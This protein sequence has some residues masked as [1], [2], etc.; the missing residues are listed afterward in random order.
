MLRAPAGAVIELI[1]VKLM[2]PSL[3]Q[4]S[5]RKNSGENLSPTGNRASDGHDRPANKLW[6]R[7]ALRENLGFGRPIES[8]VQTRMSGSFGTN[9]ET[10]RV[11]TDSS[12]ARMAESQDARAFTIGN[13]IVFGAGEYRPGV[14][15]GDMLLAHEIAHSL[16]QRGGGAA[17]S[18]SLAEDGANLAA[19]RALTRMEGGQGAPAVAMLRETGGLRLQRCQR[20]PSDVQRALDGQISWTPTLAEQAL[21]QYRGLSDTDRRT[22]FDR[23]YP[24]GTFHQLLQALPPGAAE[25]AYADVVRDV[26]QR[27]Q[28][29]GVMESARASGLPSEANMAQTQ[30]TFMQARNLAAAQ[31]A[32]PVMAPPPTQAQVAAQ[33]QTQVAQTSIPPSTNALSPA[34]IALWTT[35]TN[36]AI[37]TFITYTTANHPQLRLTAADLHTDVPGVEGRGQNVIAYGEVVGGRNVA[38]VGR[39]FVQYVQSNPAYALGTVMHELRG[40]P[41][42]GTYG[43]PGT[44]YGLT[45]YDMASARMP[46]YTQPTG[47]GRTSE[48]DA[49]AYQETEIYSLLRQSE[50]NVPLAPAHTSTITN[51]PD[52]EAWITSRIRIIIQQWEARIAK[53]LLRGMYLRFQLDPRI[54]AAALHIY[55]RAVRANYPGAQ[56]ATA[57]DILK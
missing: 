15:S 56:A 37:T 5:H 6:E 43:A 24:K 23:Y 45:L 55:E 25:G 33:Q 36:T 57:N 35:R 54:T 32:Q 48:L 21:G 13:E 3:P 1:G 2:R 8:P 42:Y 18:D 17:L 16:Q 46:G 30:A 29:R 34:D 12:A 31:A 20:G 11:H 27:A 19:V 49:Y 41:E 22:M 50:Y 47:A 39:P 28:I 51:Y 52:P 38:T 26:V 40:H 44:E 10:I 7:L 9:L 4:S 14:F 53:A